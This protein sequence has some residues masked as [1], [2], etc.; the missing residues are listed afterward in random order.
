MPSAE[1]GAAA[2]AGGDNAATGQAATEPQTVQQAPLQQSKAS[3]IIRRGDTLWQ[4][5]RR[6]YGAG[7]RYTTIYLANEAQINNPDRILPGQIFGVPDEAMSEDELREMHRK[8][9][10]HVPERFLPAAP[11]R[12][13]PRETY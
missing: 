7:V 5:S 2:T 3:V 8:H 1:S 12:P 11:L 13:R 4:I 6:V 10:K 9:M